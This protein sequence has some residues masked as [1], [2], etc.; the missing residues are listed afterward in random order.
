MSKGKQTFVPMFLEPV[1]FEPD[2]M[3]IS[4][5]QFDKYISPFYIDDLPFEDDQDTMF[6][7]FNL[8]PHDIRC[9]AIQWGASDTVFRGDAFAYLIKNQ[10]GLSTNEFYVQQLYDIKSKY[11]FT[12]LEAAVNK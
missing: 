8:L 4:R 5:E 10:F 1:S 11:D 9:T 3:V 12:K 7:V 2:E 6:R